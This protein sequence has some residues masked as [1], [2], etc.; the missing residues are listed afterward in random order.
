MTKLIVIC[1][2]DHTISDARWRD[3]LVGQWNEFY[4]AGQHDAPV[5]PMIRM[6]NSL[7]LLGSKVIHLTGR[8][9]QWRGLTLSWMAKHKVLSDGILMRPQNDFRPQKE[10]KPALVKDQSWFHEVGLV[11]DD[12]EDVLEAFRVL[13]VHT[14][15]AGLG[16]PVTVPEEAL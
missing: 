16:G 6:V 7:S 9:E 4:L 8:P 15:R 1:D 2:L 3:H 13:G 11:I 14:L 5:V 12:R 10:L